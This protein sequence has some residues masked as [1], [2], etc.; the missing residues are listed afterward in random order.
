MGS[1]YSTYL[2]TGKRSDTGEADIIHTSAGVAAAGPRVGT[3]SP[4]QKQH[5]SSARWKRKKSGADGSDVSNSD[6]LL[7]P[8][9]IPGRMFTNDAS[10]IACLY[11]QQGKKG[12]NQDAM[13]VWEVSAIR[14][15][16]IYFQSSSH[17][18][19]F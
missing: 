17:L 10:K 14:T 6:M 1:C 9:E 12:I 13:L 16:T 3:T 5:Q 15:E 18:M 19:F 7:Y 8:I 2:G 11:T 4:R